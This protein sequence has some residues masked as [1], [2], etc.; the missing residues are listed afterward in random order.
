MLDWVTAFS[1]TA[2][3][4][5]VINTS[6]A[7]K[8]SAS[9]NSSWFSGLFVNNQ[10]R[11]FTLKMVSYDANSLTSKNRVE[12]IFT[13]TFSNTCNNDSFCIV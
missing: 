5:T 1:N 6:Q 3:G 12:E 9:Y 2:A 7:F 4:N 11:I 13:V 8:V 10:G